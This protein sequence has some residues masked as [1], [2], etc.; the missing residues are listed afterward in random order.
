MCEL[1]ATGYRIA[2]KFF[3][4]ELASTHAVCFD[5]KSG[6]LISSKIFNTRSRL[7]CGRE[8]K[9]DLIKNNVIAQRKKQDRR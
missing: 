8:K 1:I 5:G 3:F 4:S 9:G 2:T 7:A 6:K